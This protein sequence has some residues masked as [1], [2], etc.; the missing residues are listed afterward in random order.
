M[1]RTETEIRNGN[2]QRK[3][4]DKGHYVNVQVG[5]Y[6]AL[7]DHSAKMDEMF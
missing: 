4:P 7:L 1:N 5:I 2:K 6:A 3:V